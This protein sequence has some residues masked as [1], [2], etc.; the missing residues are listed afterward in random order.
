MPAEM[1][2]QFVYTDTE[3]ED[4]RATDHVPD[5]MRLEC[6]GGPGRI[7]TDFYTHSQLIAHW[8][9]VVSYKQL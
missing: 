2:K 1:Q 7:V 5:M 6:F 8:A 9:C 3:Q 4:Q